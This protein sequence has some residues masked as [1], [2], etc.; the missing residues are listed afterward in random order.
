M[1]SKSRKE[2]KA[3]EKNGGVSFSA[4]VDLFMKFEV[5]D[6]TPNVGYYWYAFA[7]VFDRF[8]MWSPDQDELSE[9]HFE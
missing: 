9:F 1:T 6:L 3:D 4:G 5:Q 8:R 2:D 7:E